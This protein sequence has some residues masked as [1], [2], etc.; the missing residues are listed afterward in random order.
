MNRGRENFERLLLIAVLESSG[1]RELYQGRVE[2]LLRRR[3][4]L[5][6]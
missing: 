5:G 4:V 6:S 2:P 1:V 3:D